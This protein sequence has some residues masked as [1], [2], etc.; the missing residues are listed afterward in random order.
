M[1]KLQDTSRTIIAMG[2]FVMNMERK[3]RL[4][5]APDSQSFVFYDFG[6]LGLSIADS[7]Q[8]S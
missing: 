2:F 5:I 6:L 4:R 7:R 8:T 3:L 1:A